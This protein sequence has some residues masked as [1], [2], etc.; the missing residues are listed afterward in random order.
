M[1]FQP[2]AFLATRK[3]HSNLYEL[4][5]QKHTYYFL[6][7]DRDNDWLLFVDNEPSPDTTRYEYRHRL[8]W[9]D[10][11]LI[12]HQESQYQLLINHLEIEKDDYSQDL[13]TTLRT[14]LR[15]YKLEQLGVI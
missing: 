4:V 3:Y 13:V 11:D 12:H 7:V 14:N 10:D 15:S 5:G 6:Y 8:D 2:S 9:Q 1:N